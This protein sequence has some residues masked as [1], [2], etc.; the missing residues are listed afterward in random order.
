M[1][2][3]QAPI[4]ALT[5]PQLCRKTDESRS[6][7]PDRISDR[8]ADADVSRYHLSVRLFTVSFTETEI[9]TAPD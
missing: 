3:N 4:D 2:G 9:F 6:L 1:L 5:V 8:E 7:P